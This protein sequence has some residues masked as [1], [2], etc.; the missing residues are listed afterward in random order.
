MVKNLICE[1]IANERISDDFYLLRIV[2]PPLASHCAPGQFI[3]LRGLKDGWP[4]LRRAF[5]IYSSDGESHIEV[6]YKVV[7]RA[8]RLMTKMKSCEK[9]DVIGPLGTSFSPPRGK[10]VAV[11]GGIGLPPLAYYCQR[12]AGIA[13]RLTLIIGASSRS[14]LLVPVGLLAEGVE[15][16]TFTEDGSRGNKGTAVEGLSMT[17]KRY[18]EPSMIIACGPQ[19]MLRRVAE[20]AEASSIACEVCVEEKMGCGLGL[21]LGCAIPGEGGGFLHACS[22]GPVIDANRIAWDRWCRV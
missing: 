6:V 16:I 21:C 8:T 12:Y 22:D 18:G 9:V 17:I 20:V 19:L 10:V 4:Y 5:S 11:A 15:V 14:E 3:F 2:A 7:G 13:E 1:V